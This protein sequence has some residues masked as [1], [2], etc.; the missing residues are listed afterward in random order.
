MN[1]CRAVLVVAAGW[2]VGPNAVASYQDAMLAHQ[3]LDDIADNVIVR[4][5]AGE[6]ATS[7]REEYYLCFK[8]DELLWIYAHSGG[9]NPK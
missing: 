1:I 3:V 2:L 4:G 9:I 5:T 7:P 6:S 8:F